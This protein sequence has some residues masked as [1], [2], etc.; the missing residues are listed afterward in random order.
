MRL[1]IPKTQDEIIADVDS[2]K[3]NSRNEAYFIWLDDHNNY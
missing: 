2:L 1:N 3:W